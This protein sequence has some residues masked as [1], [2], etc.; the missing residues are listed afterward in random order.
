MFT[1]IKTIQAVLFN[2]RKTESDDYIKGFSDCFELLKIGFEKSEQVN[3]KWENN[4]LKRVLYRLLDFEFELNNQWVYRIKQLIEENENEYL[5]MVNILDYVLKKS[6]SKAKFD[7]LEMKMQNYMLKEIIF[8]LIKYKFNLTAKQIT[9]LS[10]IKNSN[11]TNNQKTND[12][13]QYI[14]G[15]E[16]N[17]KWFDHAKILF[18]N[19]KLHEQADILEKILSLLLNKEIIIDD[20][21]RVKSLLNNKNSDDSFKKVYQ[22]LDSLP[23]RYNDR[24]SPKKLSSKQKINIIKIINEGYIPDYEIEKIFDYVATLIKK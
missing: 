3:L 11:K 4:R 14:S 17:D 9:H 5:L 7:D 20:I 22:Y 19:D 8:T 6:Y 13:I 15:I 16:I 21:D 1:I 24:K 18:E 12:I 10:K 2:K 23:Y